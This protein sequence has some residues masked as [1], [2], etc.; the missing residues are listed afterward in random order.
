MR[1]V[2]PLSHDLCPCS[3]PPEAGGWTPDA[4]WRSLDAGWGR[5]DAGRLWP[6]AG[7]P[8]TAAEPLP[9]PPIRRVGV[10]GRFEPS[11]ATAED[12]PDAS[13]SRSTP[14]RP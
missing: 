1:R 13:V 9:V 2:R 11:L 4:G 3:L 8:S 10:L 7:R 5:L 12:L 6:E 14:V